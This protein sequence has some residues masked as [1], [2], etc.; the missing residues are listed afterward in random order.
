[1]YTFQYGI[2]HMYGM[3]KH[4]VFLDEDT[5]ASTEGY[6]VPPTPSVYKLKWQHSKDALWGEFATI[7][8]NNYCCYSYRSKAL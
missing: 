1:M 4:D 2:H 3:Q 6:V 5:A 7:G 8:L